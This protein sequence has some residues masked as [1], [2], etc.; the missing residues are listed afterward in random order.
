MVEQSGRFSS[1]YSNI[2][3]PFSC[4][5]RV[6][7]TDFGMLKFA[8]A[9]ADEVLH[10]CSF[11]T[12][13]QC[14]LTVVDA[15]VVA[16]GSA[17][18]ARD[19]IKFR[20]ASSATLSRLSLCDA[21]QCNHHE[22]IVAGL[23]IVELFKPRSSIFV[24]HS[25]ADGTTEFIKRLKAHLE[26]QTLANVWVD[27][28]GLNQQQETII[29]YFRDA[30]CQARIVGVVLTP[31]YLTRPN[32]LRE[33]RW[34]LDFEEKGYLKVGLL[35]MHPAVT[36]DSRVQLV[37]NGASAWASVFF[38]GEESE[39][40]VPCSAQAG[41]ATERHALEHAAVARAAG[42]AQRHREQRLVGK[43]AVR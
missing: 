29:S 11:G 14:W 24:S 34:A 20:D 3:E 40:A 4:V 39:A 26:Q 12:R 21:L 15:A 35:S 31:T 6:A 25:W 30:L 5:L 18:I 8:A 36:F 1:L 17:W 27:Q 10:S 19:W 16:A 37:Q 7:C 42:V 9:C 33:L 22:E 23:S 28:D 41:G 2:G 43:S 32:C 13:F 38:K